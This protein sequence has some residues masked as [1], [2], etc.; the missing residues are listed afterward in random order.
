MINTLKTKLGAMKTC[1]AR[2]EQNPYETASIACS[3]FVAMG[4]S[5]LPMWALVLLMI[6]AVVLLAIGSQ[7]PGSDAN[8]A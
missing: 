2:R 8:D 3:L 7:S 5:T 6:V 4:A 1:T